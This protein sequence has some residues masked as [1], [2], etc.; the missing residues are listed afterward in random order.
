MAKGKSFFSFPLFFVRTIHPELTSPANS[1]LLF[2][3]LRKISPELTSVPIFP[4]FYMGCLHSM[5]DE[6]CRSIPCIQ[7]QEPWASE[8][9]CSVNHSAMGPA[10]G[11]VFLKTGIQKQPQ[12]LSHHW[13]GNSA[14]QAGNRGVCLVTQSMILDKVF[15][16]SRYFSTRLVIHDNLTWNMSISL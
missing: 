4:T 7:T 11:Q 3:C 2:F 1:S 6:W 8:A 9:E 12:C 10:P 16:L 5:A 14:C 13:F 15:T